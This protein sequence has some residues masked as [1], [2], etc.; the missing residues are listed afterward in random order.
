MAVNYKAVAKKNPLKQD[1]PPKYYAN[2][3]TSGNLTL[4]QL[5]KEISAISTVSAADTMAVLEGL[6][7]VVPKQLANGNIVRLG[8]F[9]SFNIQV[10]S[11]GKDLAKDLTKDQIIKTSVKFRAGKE[12]MQVINNIDF[13]KTT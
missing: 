12:F 10:K 9:G 11:E 2:I 6:L 3:V 7:E 1:D 13:T 5:A 4:R 8:E